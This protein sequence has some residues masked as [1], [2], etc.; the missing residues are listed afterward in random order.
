MKKNLFNLKKAFVA[1]GIVISGALNAF[2]AVTSGNWSSAATWGGVAPGSL[3]SGSDIIIPQGITVTLDTD[4]TFSGVLNTFS[5]S[6]TLNTTTSNGLMIMQGTLV[7]NGNIS[8]NRLQF[9]GVTTTAFSGSITVNKFINASAISMG[10]IAVA[11]ITDSLILETGSLM[12]NNNS[13]LTMMA[14]STIRVNN[15]IMG[16]VG[17]V[18][19]SSNNYNVMYVGTSKTTSVELN[20]STVQNLY[21]NLNSNSES[22]TLGSNT[23]VN[24]GLN[25]STG[26]LNL[27]GRR[28][29]LN[30][31]LMAAGGTSLVSNSSSELVVAGTGSL[32]NGLNFASNASISNLTINRSGGTVRLYSGLAVAGDLNLTN[33]NLNLE[34]GSNL[35]MNAGSQITVQSGMLT[36]M[37]SANFNGSAAYSVEYTGASSYTAG[38]ELTGS[39]V[40]DVT[41]NYSS[42]T[43]KVVLTNSLSVDGE[44]SL[45]NGQL[46]MNGYNVY[47]NGTLSQNMNGT[48]IGNSVSELHLNLSSAS[49]STLYFDGANAGNQLISRLRVNIAGSTA[50]VIGSG[51][52]IGNELIF[53]AGKI[54]LDSRDLVIQS[55]ASITGYTDTR[56]VATSL[57]GAGRL[58][59]NVNSGSTFVTFPVGTMTNY[60]PAHIQQTSLGTSG[61]FMVRATNEVLLYGTSGPNTSGI[62]IVGRTW[63][64]ESASTVSVNMNLKLGWVA[65]AEMNSFNRNSAMIRHY[66]NSAWDTYAAASASVGANTTFELMR[67]GITSLSP[68]AVAE[69]GAPLKVAEQNSDLSFEVYPVPARDQVSVKLNGQAASYKYELIDLTGRKITA[70]EN[71]QSVNTFDISNLQSGYYFIKVTN[72]DDNS[73]ATKRFVKN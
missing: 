32:T 31:D 52:T 19:N 44:L 62:P 51:L 40:D 42:T 54:M 9:S 5:V 59:M 67:G 17:G 69:S 57:N 28:L 66:T 15:G 58:Q 25:L 10:F 43:A 46:D 45:D 61:M 26:R 53:V 50:L 4:V 33:G 64:I 70:G 6:G 11:N 60:S 1:L 34:S 18:F 24:A 37:N 29:T 3:V 30:G 20:G 38:I 16:V 65:A 63:H 21:V 56:Y 23:T 48:F 47:L 22:V 8:I 41:V 7:G 55:A 68:F 72:L 71:A 14:G 36:T 39:G 13:N 49:N 12:L 73:T 35:T 27:G 2:T